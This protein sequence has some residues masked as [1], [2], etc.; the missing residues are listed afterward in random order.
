MVMKVELTQE[1]LVEVLWMVVCFI[2]AS[3]FQPL[4]CIGILSTG[5]GSPQ[6]S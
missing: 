3:G 2:G 6:S 5:A 1:A 4:A